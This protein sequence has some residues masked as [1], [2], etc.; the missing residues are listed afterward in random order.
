MLGYCWAGD[1]ETLSLLNMIKRFILAVE[2]INTV[3]NKKKHF[4]GCQWNE[5]EE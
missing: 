3:K 5:L 2:C 4:S 1:S